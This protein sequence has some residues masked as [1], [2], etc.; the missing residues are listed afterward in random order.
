MAPLGTL[1]Q[2]LGLSYC[3]A[4]DT[5]MYIRLGFNS[6]MPVSALSTTLELVKSWLQQHFI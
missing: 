5:Q 1:L 2:H 6:A 4:D 3:Y